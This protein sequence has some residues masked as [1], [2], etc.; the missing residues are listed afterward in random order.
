[1]RAALQ[2]QPYRE[3]QITN[4]DLENAPAT[5]GYLYRGAAIK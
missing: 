5:H 2:R 1:V 3:I 4:F